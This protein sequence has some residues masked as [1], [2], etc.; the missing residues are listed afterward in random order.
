MQ[1]QYTA[2]QND[3]QSLTGAIDAATI[4]EARQL[5]SG[6]GLFPLSLAP[7]GEAIRQVAV[8]RT[9][10]RKVR[11]SDLLM[12]TSQLSIMCQSGIDLAEALRAAADDCGN[13]TLRQ[14]LQEVYRDVSAGSNVSAALGRHVN[15][16]GDA[17]IASI[18]AAEASGTVNE[19]LGRLADLLRNEIRMRSALRATLAYPLVLLSVAGLVVTALVFFVLPQFG[20]VFASLGRPAP[21]ITKLIID[22]AQL[23]RDHSLVIAIAVVAASIALW[24]LRRLDQAAKYWDGAVLNF[25]LLRDA[26]RALLAGRMFRLMGTM[27]QTGVPLLEA[28]RLCRC[29]VKNRFFRRAFDDMEREVLNGRGLGATIGSTPFIPPGAAQM[30]ATAEKTGKLAMVMQLIGDYYEDDGERQV[31]Q[32][33]RL[34]EPAVIVVMGAFVAMVV[35]AVIVPLLDVSTMSG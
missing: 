27:L 33:V 28:V 31:K 4:A 34:L 26:T 6:Q 29:S 25:P 21:P 3:G 16:F 19:V 24:N 35:L 18:A 15:V 9:S 12:L 1:F 14:V 10:G 17:Y 23:L 30:I 7:A 32:L 5:L 8:G 22:T 2:K 13:P 11:R 20:K